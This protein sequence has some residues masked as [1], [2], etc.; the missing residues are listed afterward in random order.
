[1][2]LGKHQI[3]Y[4]F[5]IHIWFEEN[6]FAEAVYSSGK[7][8]LSMWSFDS[9]YP[10]ASQEEALRIPDRSCLLQEPCQVGP[11]LGIQEVATPGEQATDAHRILGDR[12]LHAWCDSAL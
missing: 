4:V 11:I 3:M 12:C 2:I 1:M 9:W 10:E 5:L 8:V 7:Y 6:I